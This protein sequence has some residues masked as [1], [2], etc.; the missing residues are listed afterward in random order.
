MSVRVITWVWDYS[1]ARGIDRLVLLALADAA[2]DGGRAWP[3]VATLAR[4]AA[5]AP[6]TVQRSLRTLAEMGELT[7]LQGGTGG[8]G[9]NTYRVRLD[10]R[11]ASVDGRQ[12]VTPVTVSPRQSDTPVSLSPVQTRTEPDDIPGDSVTP[13]DTAVTR[14]VKNLKDK[15]PS[16]P[17]ASRGT[18]ISP[19][20]RRTAADVAWQHAEG[21]TDEFAREHTAEFKDWFTAAPGQ[22]GVKLDWSATWRVWM[23]KARRDAQRRAPRDFTAERDAQAQDLIR[24]RALDPM[25]GMR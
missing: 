19:D 16:R 11:V 24:R 3:S 5:V 6:R 2:D 7:L 9:T 21:I 25:Q 10:P 20:W 18:R 1:E 13:H 14:T 8:K 15:P 12:A 22:R 17:A 4:K 23:R